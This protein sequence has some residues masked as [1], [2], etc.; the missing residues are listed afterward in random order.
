MTRL[1]GAAKA[2]EAGIAKPVIAVIAVQASRND[3]A[4]VIVSELRLKGLRAQRGKKDA[5][6]FSGPMQAKE[7]KSPVNAEGMVQFRG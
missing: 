5:A 1:A 3:L 2:C 7:K 6:A 4:D